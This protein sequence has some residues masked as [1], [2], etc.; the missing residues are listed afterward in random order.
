MGNSESNLFLDITSL[1]L[2]LF[3]F[4]S[5]LL[6]FAFFHFISGLSSTFVSPLARLLRRLSLE[7]DQL[8]GHSVLLSDTWRTQSLPVTW[9]WKHVY[10]VTDNSVVILQHR[11]FI[12][13][14][15]RN[16]LPMLVLQERCFNLWKHLFI[17]KI[18]VFLCLSLV[19]PF[20]PCRE[21]QMRFLNIQID[22]EFQVKLFQLCESLKHIYIKSPDEE[23]SVGKKKKVEQLLA[24]KLLKFRYD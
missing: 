21:T 18:L 9:K 3:Y 7:E 19:L 4:L 17:L 15:L 22:R 8:W 12:V 6:R 14:E 2:R 24:V 11:A 23:T 13:S 1:I 5:H 10:F 20:S 16:A